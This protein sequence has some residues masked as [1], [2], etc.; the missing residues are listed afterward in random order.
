MMEEVP[1]GTKINYMNDVEIKSRLFRLFG[2]ILLG[3]YAVK[4]WERAVIDKMKEM[5]EK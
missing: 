5:L 3:W 1:E 2:R 4:F